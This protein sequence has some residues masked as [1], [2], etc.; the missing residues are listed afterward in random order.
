MSRA[1]RLGGVT[2]LVLAV[3][4]LIGCSGGL[5]PTLPSPDEG[6]GAPSGSRSQPLETVVG[7]A[8]NVSGVT[9]D[10]SASLQ[11]PSSTT[12]AAACPK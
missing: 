1:I 3:A 4:V 10:N 2:V 7:A 12:A 9:P 11:N 5:G 8:D 6:D